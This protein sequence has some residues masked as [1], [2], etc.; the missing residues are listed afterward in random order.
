[1]SQEPSDVD[2]ERGDAS[3]AD[4]LDQARPVVADDDALPTALERG[5][6]VPEQDALDQAREVRLDDDDD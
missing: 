5:I 1:M 3:E 6:E 4:A 2:R